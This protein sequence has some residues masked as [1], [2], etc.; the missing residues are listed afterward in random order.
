GG[1]RTA[2]PRPPPPPGV[3]RTPPPHPPP[4]YLPPGPAVSQA[5]PRV[6]RRTALK[7]GAA[8]G[9][10]PAIHTGAL[11]QAGP[12]AE[13]Y[14]DRL[15][16]YP[17]DELKVHLSSSVHCDLEIARLGPKPERARRK[18]TVPAEA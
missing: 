18:A 3:P 9:L 4:A 14:A 16:Y 10:T 8:L 5:S 15:S 12:P 2:A 7:A 13:G 11:G 6:T 17:G 1:R